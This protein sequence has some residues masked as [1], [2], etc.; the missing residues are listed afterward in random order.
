MNSKTKII[1]S[2]VLILFI[3]SII[4]SVLVLK[5]SEKHN[6]EIVQDGKII[7]TFDLNKEPD[8]SIVIKSPDGNSSN[9]VTIENGEIFMSSAECPDKTCV[10]MGK[11]KSEN[12]PIVCLPNRLVIKFCDE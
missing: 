11:L 3:V 1:L 8:R 9:T 10:N 2:A 5:P 4:L 7:Y 12:M 6:V